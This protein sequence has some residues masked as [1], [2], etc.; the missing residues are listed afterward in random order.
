MNGPSARGAGVGVA[1]GV[2]VGLCAAAVGFAVGFTVG[3][4][5]GVLAADVAD[6]FCAADVVATFADGDGLLLELDDT[7]PVM[8]TSR[9]AQISNNGSAFLS[10]ILTC[11]FIILAIRSI[12]TISFPASPLA[13]L[14]NG[15]DS[16]PKLK[17]SLFARSRSHS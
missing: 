11:C 17:S 6:S 5:V 7:H 13:R 14:L 15:R 8:L 16:P 10:G 3:A 2:L 4:A 9:I 12:V 1:V